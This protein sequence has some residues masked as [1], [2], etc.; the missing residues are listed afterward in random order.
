MSHHPLRGAARLGRI[1]LAAVVL[2]ACVTIN[3]YFPEAAAAKA[4]DQIIDAV[5]GAVGGASRP[6]APSAIPPTGS[7]RHEKD[8]LLV[9]ALENSSTRSFP[10]HRR[11]TRPTSI[12]PRPRS[13]PSP[14]R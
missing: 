11:R 12:S 2:S 13:A 4:A 5:T 1:T 6:V 9:V 8:N 7:L 10:Q 14:L 3:V